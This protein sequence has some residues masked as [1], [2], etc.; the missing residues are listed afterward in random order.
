MVLKQGSQ[1]HSLLTIILLAYHPAKIVIMPGDHY[2][3]HSTSPGVACLLMDQ[4]INHFN[5][6]TAPLLKSNG[7]VN[8]T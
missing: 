5:L 8:L 4:Q 7:E 3:S 2:V 1:Q 6:Q